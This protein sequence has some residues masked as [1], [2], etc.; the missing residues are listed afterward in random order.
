MAEYNRQGV[1]F[2]EARSKD[3]R[4]DTER[5]RETGASGQ[6]HSM[7]NLPYQSRAEDRS[8]SHGQFRSHPSSPGPR[9]SVAQRYPG[10]PGALN[11]LR[12]KS[13]EK[14]DRARQLELQAELGERR[15]SEAGQTR[16]Q[17]PMNHRQSRPMEHSRGAAARNRRESRSEAERLQEP[18]RERYRAYRAVMRQVQEPEPNL[19]CVRDELA[20]CH[21]PEDSIERI[22]KLNEDRFRRNR[23]RLGA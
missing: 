5:R 22:I 12:S 2:R 23:R 20:E 17:V 16:Q 3:P 6:R 11:R 8:H 13:S 14:E 21:Y 1:L 4:S 7:S 15:R 9:F 10:G 19:Q 18:K